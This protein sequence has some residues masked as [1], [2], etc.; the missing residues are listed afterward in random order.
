MEK[1]LSVRQLKTAL[2]QPK[3]FP[4]NVFS[5]AYIPSVLNYRDEQLKCFLETMTQEWGSHYYCEGTKSTGKTVTVLKFLQV[6]REHNDEHAGIYL[7][8]ERAILIH[9]KDAVEKTLDI[10]L[11][12]REHPLH[13]FHYFK[14]PHIHVI[15]DDAQKIMHFR[16]FN[17]FLHSLYE[18][19][20]KNEKIIHLKILG[21][22]AFPLFQQQIR[23]DVESRYHFKPILFNNYKIEEI[24]GILRQ[25][26]DAGG[27]KYEGGATNLVAARVKRLATDLR[28]GLEILQNAVNIAKGKKITE[29][30]VDE[31][32]AQTK[33][34]YWTEQLKAMDEH[35][36]ILLAAATHLALRKGAK[37]VVTL[38]INSLYRTMC[39]TKGTEPLYPQ[40]LNY[41][42][43]KLIGQG[44]FSPLSRVSRGRGGKGMVLQYEMTPETIKR[45]IV[46]TLGDE[47]VF[48]SNQTLVKEGAADLDAERCK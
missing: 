21:T 6:L 20:V 35:S 31:A 37:E 29:T 19:C 27:Y 33:T 1:L 4:L 34:D 26:L 17:D 22:T 36:L 40:R 43:S 23:D 15:I 16:I 28:L 10:Q 30:I 32:W 44:W 14:Q 25:R 9:F 24:I 8:T 18:Q 13:V 12:F 46:K 2:M 42:M 45:A 39:Y 41:L 48:K 7:R 38:D 3:T 47:A 5:T 11:K